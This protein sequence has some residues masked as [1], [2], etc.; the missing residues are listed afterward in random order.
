MRGGNGDAN[1]C[2]RNL[3]IVKLNLVCALGIELCHLGT[4]IAE[5]H[6]TRTRKK[7]KIGEMGEVLGLQNENQ[8]LVKKK[9]GPA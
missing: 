7:D 4:T 9:G 3:G 8:G 1:K 2:S 5:S 6:P